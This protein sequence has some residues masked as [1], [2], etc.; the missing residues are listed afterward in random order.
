MAITTGVN[1][2][3]FSGIEGR[4]WNIE[5]VGNPCDSNYAAKISLP[6]A[7][8]DFFTS[9]LD[10]ACLKYINWN[11]DHECKR[12][13]VPPEGSLSTCFG[14]NANICD[15]IHPDPDC[16]GPPPGCDC[17]VLGADENILCGFTHQTIRIEIIDITTFQNLAGPTLLTWNPNECYYEANAQ[18]W[19][20][21][22]RITPVPKAGGEWVINFGPD[23]NNVLN[24]T[25]GSVLS[26]VP[27]KN[28]LR[29]A[30]FPTWE[31]NITP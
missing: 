31:F 2:L 29:H 28:N 30:L 27:F 24:N 13:F 7:S 26:P 10:T 8:C 14:E 9:C 20:D 25:L 19:V 5:A 17:E 12:I 15:E 16:P 11:G 21:S 1:H 6:S 22:W 18:M 4:E 23:E 3:K